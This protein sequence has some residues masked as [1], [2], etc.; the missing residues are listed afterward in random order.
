MVGTEVFFLNSDRFSFILL[1][2]DLSFEDF[3]VCS[4][5]IKDN[6]VSG[7]RGFLG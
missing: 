3:I 6:K 4:F 2:D 7:F 1:G 5:G